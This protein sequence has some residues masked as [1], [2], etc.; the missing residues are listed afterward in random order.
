LISTK[1]PCMP[2]WSF[3]GACGYQTAERPPEG[4]LSK[5]S[6]TRNVVVDVIPGEPNYRTATA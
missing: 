5:L 4:G 1:T 6:S 3:Q 2:L